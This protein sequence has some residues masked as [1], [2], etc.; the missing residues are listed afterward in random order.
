MS[1]RDVEA[2]HAGQMQSPFQDGSL[3]KPFV[4]PTRASL[5]S[6]KCRILSLLLLL[7][8]MRV[9][10]IARKLLGS[11]SDLPTFVRPWRRAKLGEYREPTSLRFRMLCAVCCV[12]CAVCCVLSAATTTLE[13]LQRYEHLTLGFIVNL[14]RKDSR[15]AP[16]S[17]ASL[18]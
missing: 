7:Q 3:R 6:I 10:K 2:A 15:A 9:D 17:R 14:G 12:L 1:T 4:P 11:R 13:R 18:L 16:S 8:C 5:S